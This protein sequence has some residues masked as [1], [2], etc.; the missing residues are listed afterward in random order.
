MKWLLV[1]SFLG[2]PSVHEL[3]TSEM[4]C[5]FALAELRYLAKPVR[6][7]CREIGH[8]APES[9]TGRQF[10]RTYAGEIR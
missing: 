2:W 6:L 1:I 7:E 3:H 10:F 8:I 9:T 5:R 4:A